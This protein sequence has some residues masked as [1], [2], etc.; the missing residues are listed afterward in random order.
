MENIDYSLMI[1]P[2]EHTG[3][4]TLSKTQA[5]QYFEWYVGQSESRINQ[6]SQ[7][8]QSMQ[9][10][11]FRCDYTPQSFVALWEWFESQI[12][13]VEKSAEEYEAELERFPFWMHESISR[14]TLSIKTLALITDISFYFAE[15]FVICNPTIHWGYFTKP[16]NEVSVNMPVLM[17]FQANMKLDPRRIVH[18]CASESCEVRE[19]NRLLN[20]YKTW[21]E[22]IAK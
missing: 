4:R 16:K 18:V 15:T 7:Y 12:S 9:E 8:I 19:K 21:L 20:A 5:K 6:L 14:E 10:T 22:Y 3:F 17:G 2:I 1:S 11:A 13:T